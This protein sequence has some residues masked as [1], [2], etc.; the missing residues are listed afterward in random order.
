L[1]KWNSTGAPYPKGSYWSRRNN[2]LD[3]DFQ[4]FLVRKNMSWNFGS[5]GCTESEVI[6]LKRGKFSKFPDSILLLKSTIFLSAAKGASAVPCSE[7]FEFRIPNTS[8]RHDKEF[9][10]CEKL[11]QNW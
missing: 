8:E 6:S 3:G 9:Q 1:F 10:I 2:S 4:I 7:I 5:A 11:K